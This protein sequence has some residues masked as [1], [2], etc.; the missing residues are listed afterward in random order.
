M[1]SPPTARQRPDLRVDARGL[2]D[3]ER[4]DDHPAHDSGSEID[5]VRS[6]LAATGLLA[7][8]AKAMEARRVRHSDRRTARRGSLDRPLTQS[9]PAHAVLL[10]VAE[11]LQ[12]GVHG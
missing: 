2:H 5:G 3:A 11:G 8:R 12:G 6:C 1:T 10:L 4:L 9:A 7:A